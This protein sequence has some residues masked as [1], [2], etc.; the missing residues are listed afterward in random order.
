MRFIVPLLLLIYSCNQPVQEKTIPVAKPKL[1]FVDSV[2]IRT[3]AGQ[4]I[5]IELLENSY[6]YKM[7]I[8]IDTIEVNYSARFH[9]EKY[10][11]ERDIYDLNEELNFTNQ[12]EDS[13][14]YFHQPFEIFEESNICAIAEMPDSILTR[15]DWLIKCFTPDSTAQRILSADFN[16]YQLDDDPENE[17]ICRIFHNECIGAAVDYIIL[18]KINSEWINAGRFGALDHSSM[19][20][21]DSIYILPPFFGLLDHGWGSAYSS[22]NLSL[23]KLSGDTVLHCLNLDEFNSFHGFPGLFTDYYDSKYTDNSEINLSGDQLLVKYKVNVSLSWPNEDSEYWILKDEEVPVQFHFDQS[24]NSFV[25]DTNANSINWLDNYKDIS[26]TFNLDNY[27]DFRL[28]QIAKTGNAKQKYL[29][30]NY[31]E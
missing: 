6:E 19:V 7:V 1:L 14:F 20:C 9:L 13:G 12:I 21:D 22:D 18:N 25:P 2:H 17:I 11:N 26:Y 24:K 5:C 8:G 27:I 23:Y 16:L 10:K 29:L 4:T 28:R 30:K 3:A 31:Q 15:Y